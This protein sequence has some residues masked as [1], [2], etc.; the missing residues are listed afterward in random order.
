MDTGQLD[1]HRRTAG[2]GRKLIPT[3][4]FSISNQKKMDV[5]NDM[6]H[7]QKFER[8]VKDYLEAMDK[9]QLDIVKM[10][11]E[12]MKLNEILH[13]GVSQQV[14]QYLEPD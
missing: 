13:D 3:E 5:S 12:S 8:N 2:L 6:E 1:R 9:I 14:E 10:L 11:E 4:G 7:R